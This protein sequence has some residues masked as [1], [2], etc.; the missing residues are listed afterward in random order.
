MCLWCNVAFLVVSNAVNMFLTHPDEAKKQDP[1]VVEQAANA[2][3]ENGEDE[4]LVA[5]NKTDPA[6]QS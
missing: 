1:V 3:P 2:D 5:E 4:E 6:G